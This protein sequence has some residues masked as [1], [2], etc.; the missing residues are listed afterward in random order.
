M[1]AIFP[2]FVM[3][4]VHFII[5]GNEPTATHVAGLSRLR[6]DE[7]V[8]FGSLDRP[9]DSLGKLLKEMGIPHRPVAVEGNYLS[10]YR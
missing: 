8:V 5:A 9:L 7:V 4:N 1:G 2:R 6:A 3:R 10:H